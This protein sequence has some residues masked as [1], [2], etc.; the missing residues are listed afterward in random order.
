MKLINL[1]K[2]NQILLKKNINYDKIQ[3]TIKKGEYIMSL[4]LKKLKALQIGMQTEITI[5]DESRSKYIGTV[6]D[7]DFEESLEI[8]GDFGELIVMFSDITAVR[9]IQDGT[10]KTEPINKPTIIS[11]TSKPTVNKTI[12]KL[13]KLSF[14]TDVSFPKLSDSE[15]DDYFK[16]VL[17]TEERKLANNMYQ[18]LKNKIRNSEESGCAVTIDRMLSDFDCADFYVSENAYRFITHLQA[19]MKCKLSVDCMTDARA[20]DYLA[21]Y[22]YLLKD[23]ENAGMYACLSLMN[24]YEDRFKD[25]IY[26]IL[27]GCTIY[28]NDTS[29]LSKILSTNVDLILDVYMQE[30]LKYIYSKNNKQFPNNLNRNAVV[31][32]LKSFS[33]NFIFEEK[34]N[35]ELQEKSKNDN[36]ESDNNKSEISSDHITTEEIKNGEIYYLSW[37]EEKGKILSDEVDYDFEYSDIKNK[38]LLNK[39][40]SITTRDLKKINS[41]IQ[42]EFILSGK[43]I[44]ITKELKTI[45]KQRSDIPVNPTIQTFSNESSLKTARRILADATNANRFE[46]SIDLFEKAL[47]EEPDPIIPLAEYINCGIAVANRN[48]NESYLEKVYATYSTFRES[49]EKT[50]GISGNVSVLDLL[51]RM[52]KNEEAILVASRI[53]ADP[54][55]TV[56][57]RLHYIF[58]RAKLYFEKATAMDEAK[59]YS[60]EDV[61]AAF[62]TAKTALMDWEQRASATPTLKN[63]S[64]YKK[65]YYNTVLFGIAS[66][67]IKTGEIAQ[68]EE[69]LKRI[70][71]FDPT[72][73]NA[74][75]LLLQL[76]S[77]DSEE[78]ESKITDNETT[79]TDYSFL[80][81][82]YDDDLDDEQIQCAEY[83]D[84]SGWAALN[85]SETDVIEYTI[86]LIA[87]NKIP[88]AVTYLKA[89]SNLNNNLFKIYNALSYATNHPFENLNYR[90]DNVVSQFDNITFEFSEFIHFSQIAAALRGSFYH[91]S[92]KDYFVASAYLDNEIMKKTPALTRVFEVIE[93][94]RADTGKGM[95][96]YADYR[97]CSEDSKELML[98]KFTSDAK[99]IYDCYFDRLFHE[100]ASQKRF[101][102]TKNIVFEK[103][104]FL[105]KILTCVKNNDINSFNEIQKDFTELFIRSGA[106]ISVENIDNSKIE[107]YLEEA[108]ALAGKDKNIHERRSSTLM[109]S[110]RNNIRIPISKIVETVCA[111]LVLYNESNTD[112]SSNELALYRSLKDELKLNLTQAITELSEIIK[113]DSMQTCSG[114]L[115]LQNTINEIIE[116]IDGHWTEEK[117]KFYFADFL[118]TNNV[119]LDEEY[120]PDLTF[121]LCDSKTF[122]I[123][124]RIKNHI[125]NSNADILEYACSIYSRDADKHDFGTADKIYEYFKFLNRESELSFPENTNVFDEQA[126]KQTRECYDKFNIDMASA[127]SRGQIKTSDAFLQS[128]D[129]TAQ[130]IYQFSIDSRNYGFFF[131]FIDLCQNMIHDNAMEYGKILETQL[132]RLS[133][134]SDMDDTTFQKISGY[135]E[136]Q[137]FTVAEEMMSRYS[138]GDVNGDIDLPQNTNGY[139][140]QFWEE[141]DMN[142]TAIARERGNNLASIRYAQRAAKDRRGSEFLV[143]NWPKGRECSSEQ[144]STLL[145]LLGWQDIEV[146]K[147]D[148]SGNNLCFAVKQNNKVFSQ[149]E[150]A[151]PIAAF[152]TQAYNDGFYVVCLFGTTD[153]AR[154]VDICRRLDSTVGNK[155]LLIDFALSEGERRRLAKLMKQVSFANTYLFIDRVSL[156]YLANHYV[157]GVGE[158]NNRALFAI[159]MPFT[160]YQPYGIGSTSVTAPELFSGR[161]KE[162]LEVES[163]QGANLIYGGR[164]LGKTAILKKAVNETHD[165]ENGRYAFAIDIKEKDCKESA[166]KVSRWLSSEGIFAEEQITEDWEMLAYYIRKNIVDKSISYIL[167]MLDEADSFID[168]CRN[169]E[170][171]PFVALKDIQ[172]SMNGKFKFVLAGLHNIVK[173]KRD[174]ALGNNSVIAHLSSINVKPFDFPTAKTLLK[175]PLEYLGFDFDDDE[176]A[177]MQICSAT[178]YY[179]G[180]LQFFCNKLIESLKVNYGGYSESI[181]PSYKVTTR[182]ISKVLADKEFMAAIKEKFEITLRLGEGNYYYMIALL[183]ALLYEENETPDGYSVT[184]IITMAENV[185]I[186][187]FEN[188]TKEHIYALL[189]EL[190]DLNILKT[191]GSGYAFRTRSFRDL[192]GSKSDI[193][194]QLLSLFEA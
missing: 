4:I 7:T 167:L 116:R 59:T 53:L 166:L 42:V 118:K 72:N 184:D 21:I 80:D 158:S 135:I 185:G 45:K 154:L 162:L 27:A 65:I 16:S 110:L 99:K 62:E 76:T 180:L 169:C 194:D 186:N 126:K 38:Y 106:A 176:A 160:Y 182:H 157:A 130:S 31:S 13:E 117:R 54:K 3:K 148:I 46:E 193:E 81:N 50:T 30:L 102:L 19:R 190:C 39:I 140:V 189:E 159:S 47:T 121:T 177:F 60:N 178:N 22:Y 114:V 36:L 108:W 95:D 52:K 123:L 1:Y 5:N 69:L 97:Y 44:T 96:L 139:L 170:Y 93:N 14:F 161:K 112:Y 125:E 175:E 147:S 100:N 87:D 129:E 55:L 192:L 142:Y 23:F 58:V 109:G 165:P 111:W 122:N 11:Q 15:L 24:K 25:V 48:K 120:L 113:T 173:F 156:L 85:I 150:Y 43:S 107:A 171:A 61:F 57:A 40:K 124:A 75:N 144:I 12:P 88:V 133:K 152:G 183:L 51:I 119:L 56:E 181:T 179:P 6:S 68:A 29:G 168:D 84:I 35:A 89:A 187:I 155:I 28:T 101:K 188:A 90:L 127:F 94:F 20:Y 64:N 103:N 92:S 34:I 146:D 151:H 143:N 172:Q 79:I 33:V 163:P 98:E 73:E 141:F 71:S 70:R 86:K 18:S 191:I 128:V 10:K 32:D 67:L 66:C 134:E 105:D 63:D 145:N 91:S 78:V 74:T 138:K 115:I 132:D 164:Q 17:T 83:R 136:T 174:V 77:S 82:I 41:V 131:R 26:T 2:I 149:R 8:Q 49:I 37:A 137:Q 153:S 104:G 9:V